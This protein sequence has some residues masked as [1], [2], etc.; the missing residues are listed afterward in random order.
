M[1]LHTLLR[2]HW[3]S[4][5]LALAGLLL[6]SVTGFTLNHAADIESR[7]VVR[8][9]QEDLPPE[10]AAALRQAAPADGLEAPLP[11]PLRLWLSQT[12][13]LHV[14]AG[15]PAEWRDG[16]LYLGLP[17]PGGD[18]W[19]R[20]D[21][22]S[23]QAEFE[24]SDRGWIAW[25]NDLHKG[26]HAGPAWAVFIDLMALACGV[27]SLTGLL[28]LHRHAAQRPLTWPLTALGLLLPVLVLLLAVH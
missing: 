9:W 23:G 24:D 12:H 17:R 3:I 20:V 10:L 21:L 25:A 26:R 4:S 13:A 1:S 19:L 22:P 11:E 5:A 27:F 18:A 16:E 8:T 14:A 2:W 15:Q 28:I 6:F 7:P